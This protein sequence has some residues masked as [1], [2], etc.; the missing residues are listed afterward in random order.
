MVKLCGGEFVRAP[1]PSDVHA[2]AYIVARPARHHH[3][4]RGV[5]ADGTLRRPCADPRWADRRKPI[6]A[7]A[8]VAERDCNDAVVLPRLHERRQFDGEAWHLRGQT[9]IRDA[10]DIAVAN[11]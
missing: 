2:L 6:G 11:A 9:L 5:L 10:N 4:R 8:A 1:G 3:E 7:G